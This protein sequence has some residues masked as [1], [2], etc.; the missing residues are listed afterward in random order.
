MKRTGE[1]DIARSVPEKDVVKAVLNFFALDRNVRVWRRN[2]GAV[3]ADYGGKRRLV[4][5]G[6]PGMSDVSGII[7]RMTCPVCGR[8]TRRGVR[9][10]IEC[11]KVGGRLSEFQKAFLDTIRKMGGVTLVAVPCPT[12]LD[13]LGFGA[14]RKDL[15]SVDKELCDDCSKR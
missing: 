11:K 3:T 10:E 1:S 14:I 12:E 9:L 13:P 8:I 4:R 5:F 6:T 15:E 2:T 7:G